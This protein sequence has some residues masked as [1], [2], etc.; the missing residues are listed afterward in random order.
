VIYIVAHVIYNLYFHPIASFPGPFFRRISRIPWTLAL[1]R[2]T[3]VFD[4][5]DLHN[6]YGPVVR[7]APNELAF[8]D[9]RAWR[10]VMGGGT[11]EIPKC[12]CSS[13]IIRVAV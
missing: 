12:I 2:G 6:K 11:S 7:L 1:L 4:A 10:D 3:A 5:A 9:P 13:I 8:R